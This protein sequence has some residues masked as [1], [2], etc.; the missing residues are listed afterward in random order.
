MANYKKDVVNTESTNSEINEVAELKNTVAMLQEQI[1]SLLSAQNQVANPII[2]D[3]NRWVKIIHLQEM[4]EGL[5]TNIKLSTRNLDFTFFGEDRDV[6][7]TE[8]QEIVGKYKHYFADNI[9][10]LS[11]KDNDLVEKYRLP[12]AEDT[13]LKASHLANLPYLSLEEL[14][15]LY[16]SVADGHKRLITRRWA[17]GYYELKDPAYADKKKVDLLNELSGGALQ[18]LLTELVE[19]RKH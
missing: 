3:V 15:T 10:A 9:I 14:E 19:K 12:K 1:K 13:I 4:A 17:Y 2:D 18:N 5:T 11:T 6:R 8:F 7:F 16:N